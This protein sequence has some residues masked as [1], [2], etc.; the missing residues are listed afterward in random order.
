MTTEEFC[1]VLTT[2]DSEENVERIANVVLEK[3]LAACVQILLIRSNYTW[4]GRIES[5]QEFL[6]LTKAKASD[7]AD[8]E[9]AITSVHAYDVPEVISLPGTKGSAAYLD[10]I[11]SSTRARS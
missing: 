5:N 3:Q 11:A 4:K 2:T 9:D 6:T 10:W 1:V 8:L 7:F